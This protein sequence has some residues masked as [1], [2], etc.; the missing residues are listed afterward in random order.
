MRS[1][2]SWFTRTKK[3]N[4][5]VSQIDVERKYVL[6]LRSRRIPTLTQLRY[7]PQYL[8]SNE[9]FL[10]RL[11]GLLI[12]SS[13]L[14]IGI[15]F[16]QTQIVMI[17]R[18]GGTYTEAMVGFPRYINPVLAVGNT[19][20]SDLTKLFF[21]GLMKTNDKN[22]LV[23]DLAE[24]FTVSEDAKT[25]TF[26]LR[27][28]LKWDDGEP[29]T[30]DDVM[31]TFQLIQDPNYSSPWNYTFKD[32]TFE[33]TDDKTLT[34]KLKEPST[35]FLAYFTIGILPTHR[36]ADVQP[37]NFLLVEDNTR[38]TG[39]G[40][41]K[42]K[43]L[44]RSHSGEIRS[45]SLERNP[46]YY[47][48]KPYLNELRFR[49]YPD[50]QSALSALHKREAQGLAFV[51]PWYDSTEQDVAN[52]I[53]DPLVLPQ[54]TALFFNLK[55]NLFD[56]KD[57]RR[58]LILATDR[59]EII[60]TVVGKNGLISEGP[61]A[62]GFA[63]FASDLHPRPRIP[64][65]ASQLLDSVGYKIGEDG[66]RKKGD[67]NLRLVITTVNEAPYTQIAN[68]IKQNWNDLG[69]EVDIQL[70]E[71][72]RFTQDVLKPRRYDILLYGELFDQT[73]DPYVFW[74]SKEA[75]DPGLN[76][77]IFINKKVDS[78]LESNRT[79]WSREKRTKNYQEVQ[80]IIADELPAIF[81]YTPV[82]Q[83]I[84]PDNLHDVTTG[85]LLSPSERFRDI[86]RWYIHTTPVLKSSLEM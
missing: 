57:F 60:D 73:L 67:N 46:N 29:L 23:P 55:N 28:G 10:L 38:P 3:Q 12:L 86:S 69:I 62:P 74:H 64:D 30:I 80:R 18:Q 7:I 48:D 42:F 77:S 75:L 6:G 13:A 58:A 56:N 70:V 4:P 8:S 83:Y 31:F 39:A 71:P 47:G 19:T 81:L 68:I 66:M 36:F 85:N 17:P 76:F 37:A 65:E 20:D 2:F 49:F 26:T 59:Q 5:A 79:E 54:V 9:K 25:Y 34:V 52:T 1:P 24:S 14:F 84:I 11:F 53:K 27:D 72:G 41:F 21:P 43:S 40:P 15:R 32:A 82:Y 16:W 33:R 63:G 78:L 50:I 45:Y 35:L 61:F 51:P 22:E 44:V